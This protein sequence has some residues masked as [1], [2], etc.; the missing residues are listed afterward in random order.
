MTVR[1]R[2]STQ[3]CRLVN[4]TVRLVKLKKHQ[5]HWDAEKG[6]LLNGFPKGIK[7]AL[8]AILEHL[9]LTIFFTPPPPLPQT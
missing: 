2:N 6:W 4:Q 7:N 9:E 3:H 8:I 1:D 5:K